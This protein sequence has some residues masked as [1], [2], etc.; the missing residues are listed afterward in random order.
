[1]RAG[2]LCTV[3]CAIRSGDNSEQINISTA[4]ALKMVKCLPNVAETIAVST[5]KYPK[6]CATGLALGAWVSG[7][8]FRAILFILNLWCPCDHRIVPFF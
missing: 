3:Q 1:M 5:E 4:I 8:P 7:H 6:L 2:D